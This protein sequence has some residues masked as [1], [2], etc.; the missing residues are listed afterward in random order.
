MLTAVMMTVILDDAH[1][2]S[3]DESDVVSDE[4]D[5]DTSTQL[6]VTPYNSVMSFGRQVI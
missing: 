1:P 3:E 4:F 2:Q 5:A 6:D